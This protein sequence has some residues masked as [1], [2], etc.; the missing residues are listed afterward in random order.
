MR[1]RMLG[2]ISPKYLKEKYVKV[3]ETDYCVY[4]LTDG[5]YTKIGI[6]ASLPNRIKQLQTGNA[7]VLK[8]MYI[9]PCESQKEAL[10]IEKDLHTHC[11]NNS[12]NGEW[13]LLEKED[14]RKI[15]F[16]KGYDIFIPASKFDFEVEG[17]VIL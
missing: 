4:F 5:E 13:F 16:R 2:M 1:N 12:I 10:K 7:R 17:I 6:A 3:E 15:C 8:A 11:K 14:I 9:I